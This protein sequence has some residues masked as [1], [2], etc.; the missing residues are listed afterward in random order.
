MDY[1]TD[2]KLTTQALKQKHDAMPSVWFDE[3]AKSSFGWKVGDLCGYV[4]RSAPSPEG[5]V[6]AV[7]PGTTRDTATVTISPAPGF[8]YGEGLITRKISGIHHI[9]AYSKRA[10]T[11]IA[12]IRAKGG[13]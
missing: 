6:T 13:S 12:Q 3:G 1:I 9:S 5:R 8:A 10:S 7:H 4:Y 11:P 2:E